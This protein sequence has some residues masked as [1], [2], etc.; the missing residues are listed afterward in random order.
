MNKKASIAVLL[1]AV[2]LL[3]AALTIYA[4]SQPQTSTQPQDYSY[5][6]INTYPHDT[7]AFTEGLIF[8]DGFLYESTGVYGAS[9]LR[10]VDL[11]TGNVIK[12]VN[13]TETLFGEGLTAVDD[14]LVQLTWKNHVGLIYDK[15][16]F[17][18]LSNYSIDTQGWGLTYDGSRLIMSDGSSQLFFVDPDTHQVI[19]SIT[20]KD[21]DAEIAQINELEYINGD[22]YANIWQTTKIAIINPITGQV[23]GWIN[24]SGLNQQHG[25]DDVLN[26]IAYDEQSSKLFVTGKYW[27][28]LY[29]IELVPTA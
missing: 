23:K 25:I 2:A 6:L 26:G 21:G 28:T 11:E 24:L 7:N 14:T 9:S 29:Q 3:V 13:L 1:I 20:V 8:K 27:P 4:F 22:V 16:S 15:A 17:A 12:Q 18:L 10:Q 19:G 5:R